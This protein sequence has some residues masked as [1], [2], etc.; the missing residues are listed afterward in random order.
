M[1]LHRSERSSPE[2]LRPLVA[3]LY[4]L[5]SGS[6]PIRRA[7]R[8]LAPI[9]E[10]RHQK[11]CAYLKHELAFDLE[12]NSKQFPSGVAPLG[13]WYFGRPGNRIVDEKIASRKPAFMTGAQWHVR[14]D[15]PFLPCFSL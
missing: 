8:D 11:G 13:R 2:G 4:Q 14:P 10:I 9:N 6:Y 3:R 12:R 5:L 1:A 7:Q 15:M